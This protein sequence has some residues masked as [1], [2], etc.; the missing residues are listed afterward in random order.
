MYSLVSYT[1]LKVRKGIAFFFKFSFYLKY[2]RKKKLKL[3]T[4]MFVG[5]SVVMSRKFLMHST[6]WIKENTIFR[7]VKYFVN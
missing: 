6:N 5:G 3:G 7:Y 2:I 4:C 1:K